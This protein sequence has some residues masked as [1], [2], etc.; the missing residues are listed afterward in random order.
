MLPLA[1]NQQTLEQLKLLFSMIL[2]VTTSNLLKFYNKILAILIMALLFFSCEEKS[3]PSYQVDHIVLLVNDD[4]VK[5]QLDSIFT[6]ADLLTTTHKEQGTQGKYYLFLNTS[7]ELLTLTDSLQA[8]Q[9]QK[10]FGSNYSQRWH[11]DHANSRIGI[12]LNATPYDTS[13]LDFEYHMYQHP[14][15]DTNQRYIM[16][17]GNSDLSD[18]FLF[19]VTPD[20]KQKEHASIT[21]AAAQVPEEIKEDLVRFL[22]HPSGVKKLTS[23]ELEYKKNKRE[24]NLSILEKVKSVQLTPSD[25]NKWIITF[26]HHQQNQTLVLSNNPTIEIRY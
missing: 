1:L 2:V 9:N 5:S 6:F 25:K 16:P 24:G 8:V 7:I 19:F 11:S 21:S 4:N 17:K 15:W 20:R 18:P 26:D 10:Y 3:S 12:G 14:D 22:T 23:I 13:V